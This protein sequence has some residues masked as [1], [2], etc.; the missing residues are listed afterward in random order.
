MFLPSH[1]W[2]F[3]IMVLKSLFRYSYFIQSYFLLSWSWIVMIKTWIR[4]V[5]FVMLRSWNWNHK[6]MKLKSWIREFQMLKT[7]IHEIKIVN[8]RRWNREFEKL[9]CPHR[10]F[11]IAT[12]VS[13][14]TAWFLILISWF[15]VQYEGVFNFCRCH[16]IYYQHR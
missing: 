7:W 11:V 10:S 12:S 6:F 16:L 5:E 1:F 9:K 13:K 2:H 8:S 4:E 14:L 3:T 15:S